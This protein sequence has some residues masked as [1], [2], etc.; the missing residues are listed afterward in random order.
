LLCTCSSETKA[1]LG[2]FL[3]ALQ[4]IDGERNATVH[5]LDFP[6]RLPALTLNAAQ[7][8][9][10]CV[11]ALLSLLLGQSALGHERGSPRREAL[12]HEHRRVAVGS[13][14]VDTND[15][16]HLPRGDKVAFLDA[17]LGDH[18]GLRRAQLQRAER[19]RQDARQAR[20]ACDFA[21]GGV[22]DERAAQRNR[23]GGNECKTRPLPD[24]N[25][26]EILC[27]LGLQNLLP[28]Q[29]HVASV[30]AGNANAMQRT[31]RQPP[32]NLN[33]QK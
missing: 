33:R 4:A 20:L 29:L 17:H 1:F 15:H 5:R 6:I 27:R 21:P 30:R 28:E 16:H 11:A 23:H 31:V 7:A 13:A 24:A 25:A 2:E 12:R 9:S 22:R 14:A 8:L 32:G 19:G 26:A 10:E 3:V 18:P